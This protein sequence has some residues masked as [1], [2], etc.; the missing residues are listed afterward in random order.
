MDWIVLLRPEAYGVD[1]VASKLSRQSFLFQF[2][3]AKD[4]KIYR[5]FED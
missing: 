4:T 1:D 2:T 5:Q 3:G